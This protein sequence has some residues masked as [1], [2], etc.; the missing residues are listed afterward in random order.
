MA[1]CIFCKIVAGEMESDQVYQDEKV[2]AFH[3]INPAAPVHL[4]V[5]PNKHIT[6]VQDLGD[7]DQALMGHMFSVINEVAEEYGVL[8]SGFRLIINN[9]PDAH[10]EVPHLHIHVLGGQKMRHPM[11]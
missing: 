8:Q 6:S 1:D 4:L 5:I 3:D 9:G 2:T 11:G 10:Q 7:D